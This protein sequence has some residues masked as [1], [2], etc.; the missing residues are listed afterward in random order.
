[1]RKLIP[2]FLLFFSTPICADQVT[3]SPGVVCDNIAPLFLMRDRAPQGCGNTMFWTAPLSCYSSATGQYL[4]GSVVTCRAEGPSL[5]KP[6]MQAC[7]DDDRQEFLS[8]NEAYKWRDSQSPP[9]T[10]TPVVRENFQ[11]PS[12]GSCPTGYDLVCDTNCASRLHGPECVP[13][14]V[15]VIL[16]SHGP[17]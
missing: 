7:V 9:S 2:V 5:M 13:E 17:S 6:D 3:I 4:G 1:M 14:G 8:D 10:P 11:S 16:N 15:N 12:N